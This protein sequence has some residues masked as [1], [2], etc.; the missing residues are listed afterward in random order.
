MYSV[1]ILVGVSRTDEVGEAA[2]DDVR[3][4]AGEERGSTKEAND[5]RSAV[6]RIYS[7]FQLN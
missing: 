4:G 6:K 5:L 3:E 2:D 7:L 1:L